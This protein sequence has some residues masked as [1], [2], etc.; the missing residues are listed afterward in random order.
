[1]EYQQN[2]II[3][4]ISDIVRDFFA[5]YEEDQYA[6]SSIVKVGDINFGLFNEQ[7]E[8]HEAWGEI[9]KQEI[10]NTS[11]IKSNQKYLKFIDTGEE[12]EIN[13]IAACINA[14]LN[15]NLTAHL[16]DSPS[17]T[18]YEI[19]TLLYFRKLIGYQCNKFENLHDVGGYYVSGGM[20]GNMA[21]LL[22][23]RNKKYPEAQMQGIGDV[24][25]KIIVPSFSSHYS[26]WNVAG[27]LGFGENNVIH[28]PSSNFTYDIIELKRI[29][30]NI[31]D[32]GK[33]VLMITVSLGDP[34]TMSIESNLCEIR[35]LCDKYNIWMHGDG[36]NGAVLKLSDRYHHLSDGF[37]L[38]DSITI[39]PHKALGLNYP[40]S[41]FLCKKESD[42]NSVISTWNIINK[43]NSLDMGM[44]TPFLNSRS[45]D[46]LRIWLVLRLLGSNYFSHI[47]DEKISTTKLLYNTCA[48]TSYFIQWNEPQTFAF[49]F[50]VMPKKIQQQITENNEINDKIAEQISESQHDFIKWIDDRHGIGFHYFNLPYCSE[51]YD[52]FKNVS[53]SRMTTV[54]A[55]HNGHKKIDSYIPAL[56]RK[57]IDIFC[58][59]WG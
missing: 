24:S 38:C 13:L 51:Y 21:A 35:R 53:N 9:I 19:S 34:Y 59:Q 3:S 37:E 18:L 29:V 32:Q 48:S 20:M 11:V 30:D 44:I 6:P 4:L 39:D 14:L 56:I 45:F 47:I 43:P 52:N 5:R 27:W 31:Y 10:I 54:I 22:V 41:L 33:E 36:A 49:I 28:A 2:K 26:N 57:S 1:M 46:S 25:D 12:L 23:S 58:E 40:T 7:G 8:K 42:F 50:Q 55:L 15:Q 17:A 16:T